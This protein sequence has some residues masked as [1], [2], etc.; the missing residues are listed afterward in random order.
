[1]YFALFYDVV[2]DHLERRKPHR[3]EHLALAERFRTEGRLVMAGVLESP[4][5]ALLVFRAGSAAEVEAFVHADPYVREGLVTAW[6]I[7]PWQ[8]AVGGEAER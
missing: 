5:Q 8:V 2:P 4:L 1:M 7:R 6:R 3:A